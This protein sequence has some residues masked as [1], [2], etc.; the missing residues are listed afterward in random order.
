MLYE[1]VIRNLSLDQAQALYRFLV[2]LSPGEEFYS[3]DYA[4]HGI[5]PGSLNGRDPK[6]RRTITIQP[7]RE[8]IEH[9]Q[10]VRQLF[11]VARAAMEYLE[12]GE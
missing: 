5:I 4:W 1:A 12:T 9:K 2:N 11:K 7:M 10:Q 6:A 8:E 3:E